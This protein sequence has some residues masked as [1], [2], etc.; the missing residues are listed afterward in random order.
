M[1][2]DGVAENLRSCGVQCAACLIVD[3]TTW[4][5]GPQVD[6]GADVNYCSEPRKTTKKAGKQHLD[7][8]RYIPSAF[9]KA[10]DG[11]ELEL[12]RC[13]VDKCAHRPLPHQSSS[14]RQPFEIAKGQSFAS[15]NNA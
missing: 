15:G 11:M 3:V 7:R 13:M 9:F 1:G 4:N 14:R 12:V 2:T 5:G 10:V 6:L 8:D